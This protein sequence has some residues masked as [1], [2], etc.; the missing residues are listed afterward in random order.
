MGAAALCCKNLAARPG[1][2]GEGRGDTRWVEGDL[3]TFQEREA[4]VG[5]AGWRALEAR[6]M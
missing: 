3:A 2:A 1:P 5:T 4:A 6:Y